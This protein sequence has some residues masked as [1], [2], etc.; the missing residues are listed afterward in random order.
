MRRVRM[1]AKRGIE[2]ECS[3]LVVNEFVVGVSVAC[4]STRERIDFCTTFF[5]QI[6]KGKARVEVDKDTG[7][8][9]FVTQGCGKATFTIPEKYVHQLDNFY[10]SQN[11]ALVIDNVGFTRPG[12]RIVACESNVRPIDIARIAKA[13]PLVPTISW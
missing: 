6:T 13:T 10:S 5:D 4:N 12:F 11:G 1:G 7:R 3:L 9:M 2:V 8:I